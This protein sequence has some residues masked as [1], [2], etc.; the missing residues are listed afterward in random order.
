MF[1]EVELRARYEI[2]LEEYI[3]HINIEARTMVDMV[4]KQIIPAVLGEITNIA[5]SINAVKTAIP[6][7]DVTTQTE[8]L[9]ESTV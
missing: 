2:K 6:D 9:K 5:N 7:L 4:K 3:K 8:L 1:T